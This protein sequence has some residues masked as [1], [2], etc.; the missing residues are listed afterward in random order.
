MNDTLGSGFLY[1][2]NGPSEALSCLN[3]GTIA[4]GS[5]HFFDRL[6]DPG[7]VTYVSQPSFFALS[8]P[9]EG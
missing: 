1:D 7:L 6:L 3:R 9:F 5:P 8:S 4:C 2:G